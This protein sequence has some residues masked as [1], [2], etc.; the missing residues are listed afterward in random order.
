MHRFCGGSLS[1]YLGIKVGPDNWQEKWVHL[2]N[3]RTLDA[4]MEQI[5]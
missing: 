2:A 4:W 3:Y 1:V 5:H